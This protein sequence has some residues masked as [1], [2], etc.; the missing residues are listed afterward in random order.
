MSRISVLHAPAQTEKSA[1][2]GGNGVAGIVPKIDA[3]KSTYGDKLH[4]L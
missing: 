4:L 2:R 1:G 3:K